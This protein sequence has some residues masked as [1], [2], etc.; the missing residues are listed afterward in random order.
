MAVTSLIPRLGG[1]AALA[2][3]RLGNLAA[4]ASASFADA[5]RNGLA[6]IEELRKS[7]AREQRA[8][9]LGITPDWY[10]RLSEEYGEEEL[11]RAYTE[12]QEG[13][14]GG[15]IDWKG[16]LEDPYE[17]VAS[18]GGWRERPSVVSYGM[19]EVLARRVAPFTA[20]LQTRMNQLIDYAEPQRDQHGTGF[21][22]R[23]RSH[24]LE[25]V[26][27]GARVQKAWTED[28]RAVQIAHWLVQCGR[29]PRYDARTGDRRDGFL[30]FLRKLV[31]DSLIQDQGNIEKQRDRGGNLLAWR[32]LDAKTI[33]IASRDVSLV[34]AFGE[35]I[36]YAQVIDGTVAA[37]FSGHDISFCIRNPRSDIRTF[38]YGFSELEMMIAVVTAILNGFEHN[39]RYFCVSGDLRVT[40]RAGMQQIKDLAGQSFEIWNGKAWKNATAVIT[41]W[42]HLVRTQLWN[43]LE[44]ET[45]PDHRFLSLP[46]PM[47]DDTDSL[48]PVWRTQRE[49]RKGDYLLLAAGG[50]EFPLDDTRFHVGETYP[51]IGYQGR[52]FHATK[53]IVEDRE[54]WE[55]IGFA[56]GDGYWPTLREA[57]TRVPGEEQP[58]QWLRI[59]PHHT[60]D[61]FLFDRFLAVCNRHGIHARQIMM[62]KHAQ[63][64]DGEWGL[65][66]IE[67][68]HNAFVRWLY[69]LGFTPSTGGKRVADVLFHAPIWLRGAVLRGWFSADGHT[70]THVTGYRTPS[71]FAVNEA[72]R[73]DAVLLLWSIGVACNNVGTGRGRRP[74]VNVQD[75]AAFVEKV[76]YL[77]PYKNVGITRAPLSATRW[78]KL[79]P[80]VALA[81]A[82]LI[83]SGPN[84]LSLSLADRGLISTVRSGKCGLSRP[85]AIRMLEEVGAPVPDVLRY[86]HVPIDVL[87]AAPIGSELMYDVEVFDDEHVFLGNGVAMHNSQGTTAKGVLTV[88]GVVPREQLRAF[89]RLWMAMVTGAKNAWRTPILNI[90]DEKAK[91]AWIDIQKSNMDMEFSK[92]LDWLVRTCCGVVGIAPEEIGLQ[93]GNLGQSGSGLSNGSGTKEK[94]DESKDRG[95]RPLVTWLQRTLNEEIVWHLDPEYEVV[96][97][98]QDEHDEQQEVD[99]L[100]KEVG[101]FMQVDEARGIRNLG[102]D[103]NGLGHLILNSNYIQAYNAKQQQQG[104]GMPPGGAGGFGG[105]S[106]FGGTPAA[107]S[108]TTGGESGSDL[109]KSLTHRSLVRRM[110]TND[111]ESRIYEIEYE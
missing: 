66:C 33:R 83:T 26:R 24:G 44:I 43:G 89:K 90:P 62:N 57:G 28:A 78:D 18:F 107:Q 60:K 36:R 100:V 95:R 63:R 79:H 17:P 74:L 111:R 6:E 49:L 99:L 103:P 8:D 41:G 101:S 85:R 10:N 91:V 93:M 48:T 59:F 27:Q 23:K 109:G 32:V 3:S 9:R 54:F 11:V 65:P 72:F 106:G 77:Q 46:S 56:L 105:V 108:N 53:A 94:I 12:K 19:L 21:V 13:R 29:T 64:S 51:G 47:P 58:P 87:D 70:H 38:G 73:K 30:T 71:L 88:S 25:P 2:V 31:R 7:T 20:Y 37:E 110:G 67:I 69:D 97:L 39:S 96:L 15:L 55:M 4:G 42:K 16:L 5:Y 81:V 76:G 84:W 35:P 80:D 52:D 34:N 104:G 82:D 45:S 92:W 102:P 40:T 14:S 75:V 61:A 50:S 68:A 98:G 22:V 86:H 1:R